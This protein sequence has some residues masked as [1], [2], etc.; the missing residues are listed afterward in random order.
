[1]RLA[2]DDHGEPTRYEGAHDCVDGS[3]A[4]RAAVGFGWAVPTALSGRESNPGAIIEVV[5]RELGG[6][7]V[8]GV[9]PQRSAGSAAGDSDGVPGVLH[10]HDEGVRSCRLV[11]LG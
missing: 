1:V 9:F 10:R 5:T 11:K 8:V 3:I 6:F 7:Q 4:S 2:I